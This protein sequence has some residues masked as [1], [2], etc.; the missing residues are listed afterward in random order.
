[1]PAPLA[2]ILH[3]PARPDDPPLTRLLAEVR[4]ALAGRQA[5]LLARAG[6][7]PSIEPAGRGPFAA[8]LADRL[9]GEPGAIVL[10]SGSVP[11]L[12][13]A[14][15]ARLVAAASSGARVARTNNRWS[16]DVLAVGDAPALVAL[17]RTLPALDADNGLPRLLAEAGVAVAELPGRE[18]LALD[19]DTPLD[20]ALV[21][22]VRG[23][24]AVIRE[25]A[26]AHG[27]AI[28]A[29]EALRATVRDPRAELLVA[30][31]S[32]SATL[33]RLERT[34]PCRVRFLAE[35]RGLRAAGGSPG[36]GG[37]PARP[38]RTTIGRLLALRGPAALGA[39]VAELADAAILDTR[40]LLADRLGRDESSWPSAEDRFAADLLR[41]D[42]IRDPWLRALTASAAGAPV[43]I[44]LGSHTLVGPGIRWLLE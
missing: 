3:R 35:E 7:R 13:P 32:G 33:R 40:V 39:I 18:R 29:L 26:V 9:A 21:A 12:R 28:P 17:L 30:G 5:G 20:V 22:R 25:A 38:P 24:P 1:M 42:A 10:G 41:A 2:L 44:V 23:A 36:A 27:L 34:L 16:S 43:P 31:R 19:I 6:A 14:D 11:L 15:A 4:G 8:G 37:V